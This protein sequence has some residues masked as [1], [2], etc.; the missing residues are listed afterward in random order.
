MKMIPTQT[1]LTSLDAPDQLSVRVNYG[2]CQVYLYVTELSLSGKE[3]R[4]SMP[5]CQPCHKH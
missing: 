1:L 4:Q 5:T 2:L 3:Q